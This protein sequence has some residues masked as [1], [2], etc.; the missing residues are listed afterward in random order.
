MVEFGYRKI[1]EKD[2]IEPFEKV[3]EK[4]KFLFNE[5]K[6]QSV[7]S[8]ASSSQQTTFVKLRGHVRSIDNEAFK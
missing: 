6:S 4:L 5:Y 1:Y 7:A 3:K 2:F 8:L